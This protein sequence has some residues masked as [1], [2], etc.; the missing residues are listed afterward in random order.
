MKK[1]NVN[2]HASPVKT[3]STLLYDL[4]TFIDDAARQLHL[5][6]IIP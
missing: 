6:D 2:T 4:D 3:T 1:A 5:K